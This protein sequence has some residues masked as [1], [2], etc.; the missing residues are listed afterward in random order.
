ML[1]VSRCV[2]LSL[3]LSSLLSP[4]LCSVRAGLCGD[5]RGPGDGPVRRDG[6]RLREAQPPAEGP[7]EGEHGA[8]GGQAEDLEDNLVHQVEA[9]LQRSQ[10]GEERVG[11]RKERDHQEIDEVFL[12]K[13]FSGLFS[14]FLYSKT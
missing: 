4:F 7:A 9:D 3:P 2:P 13:I 11:T 14:I 6:A 1:T 5:Q 8:D 12:I 10:Q